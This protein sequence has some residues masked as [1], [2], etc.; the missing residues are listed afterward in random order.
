MCVNNHIQIVPLLFW[1]PRREEQILVSV[2]GES[3]SGD[4]LV[5]PQMPTLGWS[6]A[7]ISPFPSL[8]F[9]VLPTGTLRRVLLK[10]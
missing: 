9:S 8:D 7:S 1:A 5:S 3:G 6:A 2:T 4:S 10:C